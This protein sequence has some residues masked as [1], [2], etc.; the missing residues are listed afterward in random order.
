MG[1]FSRKPA[2]CAICN[3]ELTHKHKPKREWNVKG[4]LC[5]DCHVDK[6]KE[7]YE[8]NDKTALCKMWD[9]KK[10][11]RLVGAKMAVGYGWSSLQGML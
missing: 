7:F 6:T 9:Y 5:G 10:D 1:L 4:A 2:Y 3:K 11:L 8:A